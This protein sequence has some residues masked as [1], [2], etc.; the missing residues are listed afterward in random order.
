[1]KFN[2]LLNILKFIY[3]L[4]VGSF[5]PLL[6][7][8]VRVFYKKRDHKIKNLFIL[9]GQIFLAMTVID[10]FYLVLV[11]LYGSF[12]LTNSVWN[13]IGFVIGLSGGI[14][15]AIKGSKRKR[16]QLDIPQIKSH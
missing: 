13:L 2:L 8:Y 12:Y 16:T 4:S 15:A 1:M 7:L 14:T 5:F 10:I 3:G 11:K 9:I 6:Y